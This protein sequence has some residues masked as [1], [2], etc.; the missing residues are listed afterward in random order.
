MHRF[1]F[2][3]CLA[4]CLLAATVTPA[5]DDPIRQLQIEAEISGRADWG[6]WGDQPGKYVTWSNHSNRLI[7]V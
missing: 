3:F 2:L 5:A 7:P 6:H 1:L 4:S